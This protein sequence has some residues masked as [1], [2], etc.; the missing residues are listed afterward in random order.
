MDK[1]EIC[2]YDEAF[3]RQEMLEETN[4]CS[5]CELNCPNAKGNQLT[6]TERDKLKIRRIK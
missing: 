4:Q 6:V 5:I 3:T 2:E 1:K